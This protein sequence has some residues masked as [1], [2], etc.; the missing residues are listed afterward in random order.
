MVKLLRQCNFAGSVFTNFNVL[1]R[2]AH[3]PVD[4]YEGLDKEICMRLTKA[5][6]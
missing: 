5:E 2:A 4:V 1:Q 3:H 6:P